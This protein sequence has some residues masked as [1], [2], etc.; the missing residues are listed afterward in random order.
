MSFA[1]YKSS[2][3]S[4]KTYTLV[5]NYLEIVLAEPIRFRNILAIT[6]TNKAANEMK[7][8]V[9]SMLGK[10]A[11]IEKDDNKNELKYLLPEL[12]KSTGCEAHEISLRAQKVLRLI[13]HN[14]A[15]FAITTIDSF[16]HRI[17]RTFSHDLQLPANFEI[18]MDTDAMLTEAI[19]ILL[20]R[21][22]SDKDL[23]SVL[24]RFTEM[25]TDE[26]KSWHIENDLK[27]V[28][29][30]QM[31]EESQDYLSIL[32]ELSIDDFLKI[33]IRLSKELAA[34]IEQVRSW[35]EV[36]YRQIE[37]A[38]VAPVA[39]F[40]GK[41]GIWGYVHYLTISA[42]D[43]EKYTPNAYVC[44]SV[45]EDK[46]YSAKATS[47]DKAAIDS[48]IPSIADF[49]NKMRS[50][51]EK[52]KPRLM[53][54]Q[55]VL[56]QLY[57]LAVMHSVNQILAEMRQRDNFIHISEFNRRIAQVVLN[58]P[59]PFLY[60]RIGDKYH[61]LM[62]DEFQDTSC[63][64]W[65]NLLPLIDNNLGSGY[66]NMVVGD[67]KQAI[68]RWRGGEVELFA[69]LPEIYG[70]ETN[71]LIEERGYGLAQHYEELVL[72]KNYR[73]K[74]EVVNFNNLFFRFLANQLPE[75]LQGIYHSLEQVYNHDN[76]G[77]VV[78]IEFLGAQRG[79]PSMKSVQ[80]QRVLDIIIELHEDGY[81]LK[82]IAILCRSN[83][84]AD[85][86]ARFLIQQN[87]P[88][89][90]SDSLLL[91]SSAAVNFL[92]GLLRL[93]QSPFEKVYR[94][95]IIE[96]LRK[97]NRIKGGGLHELIS[98]KGVS[99]DSD[100]FESLLSQFGIFF[101][102]AKA[103]SQPVYETCE[104]LLRVFGLADLQDPYIQFFMDA[105]LRYS[106]KYE[107]S[108]DG[109]LAYWEE[110]GDNLSLVVPE[111]SDAVSIMTIHKSKGLEFKV[112]IY[113]FASEKQK[114]TRDVV[115]E[116]AR[117]EHQLDDLSVLLLPMSKKLEE[118]GY[119]KSYQLEQQKS[120][121]DFANLVY[122]AF[123]RPVDRL[124]VLCPE[125]VNTQDQLALPSL[126]QVFIQSQNFEL[127]SDGICV[128]GNPKPYIKDN[129]KA[130]FSAFKIYHWKSESREERIKLSMTAP[131][132]WDI[133]DPERNKQY[134]MLLHKVLSFVSTR[135]D[136]A[137]GVKRLQEQGWI[138]AEQYD[139]LFNKVLSVVDHEQVKSFFAEGLVIKTEPDIL[140]E[141]GVV[142]RPDK[143]VFPDKES[144]LNMFEQDYDVIVVDYKTGRPANSHRK[145]VEKYAE[146]LNDMGYEKVGKFL[147][148]IDNKIK[149]EQV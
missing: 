77:G 111:S 67:G 10:L 89:I 137:G 46:W 118:V 91:K 86:L 51:I 74:A 20:N 52:D 50:F 6:F 124:Y 56:K 119:G 34:D 136:V 130:D 114:N 58:E 78:Q 138:E 55:M 139:A 127:S 28:A 57:P 29:S 92:V 140:L 148:Y 82:D 98:G 87:V 90:S 41:R 147:I 110:K 42:G 96:Y 1:V 99:G 36:V 9:L 107:G 60:E 12:V 35:A 115:W 116:L 66:L 59:V 88:V 142:V 71:P 49:V 135:S 145:Q 133:D 33:Y 94:V 21:V 11:F 112:V 121:L 32:S 120:Q 83:K 44:K 129:K 45:D 23:T 24:V 131:D 17:I 43:S 117:P 76:T 65:Y 47:A 68:Y 70:A 141:S 123:T 128:I 62:V 64:Q 2:A 102:Y 95:L 5:K 7:A 109:F 15:D 146:I 3:G 31:D 126:L 149:V 104:Y 97:S 80:P 16:V 22:G 84:N 113:P 81:A 13:L 125:A 105:V 48:L 25:K 101:S 79:E 108:L 18:Q 144:V 4:G 106:A 54:Y 27:R 37:D 103:N 14:Y 72:D 134:G 73:S 69:R 53:L 38:G 8:R 30:H 75:E 85:L 100:D 122:V 63:L 61:H 143:L 26:E 132:M 40:Q 19:D 39:F 93:I